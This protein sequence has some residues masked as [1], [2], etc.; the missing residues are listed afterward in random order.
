MVVEIWQLLGAGCKIAKDMESFE[1]IK[2]VRNNYNHK[3]LQGN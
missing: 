2:I 1:C 3:R